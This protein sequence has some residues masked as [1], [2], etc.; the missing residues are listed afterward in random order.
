[1]PIRDP[2]DKEAPAL[3]GIVDPFDRPQAQPE[4]AADAG[5]RPPLRVVVPPPTRAGHAVET[6]TDI[7]S[8]VGKHFSEGAEAFQRSLNPFSESYAKERDEYLKEV[9]EAPWY[10]IRPTVKRN[11]GFGADV[12]GSMNAPMAPI[13]GAAE[14]VLSHGY[15]ALNPIDPQETEELKK[16]GVPV[17]TGDEF[18]SAAMSAIRPGFRPAQVP[19]PVGPP[20]PS[21]LKRAPKPTPG[22]YEVAPGTIVRKELPPKSTVVEPTPPKSGPLGV[23]LSKGQDTLL[24]EGETAALPLIQAEQSAR[25]GILGK[26]AQRRHGRFEAQQEA[27]IAG[28]KDAFLADMNPA[29]TATVEAP[30]DAAGYLAQSL[31]RVHSNRSAEQRA[32]TQRLE[33]AGEVMRS[34]LSPTNTVL[35]RDPAE[36]AN[37]LSGSVAR[38]A[39]VAR[40]VVNAAYRR[41][42]DLPGQFHPATFNRVASDLRARLASPE[43]PAQITL[44]NAQ[45]T[46]QA[47]AAL[48]D[49]QQILGGIA[50]R[51]DP[52]TNRVLPRPPV[53]PRLVENAR[54]RLNTFYGN[55]LSAARS[56]GNWADARAME[57]VMDAFDGMVVEKLRSTFSGGSAGEFMSAITN[58]RQAYRDYRNTYFSR[59]AGDVVGP[60][61]QR[62]LGRHDGQALTPEQLSSVLYSGTNAVPVGRR[63]V[64]V[65]GQ[66]SPEVG[67]IKQGLWSH[68]TEAPPGK[69]PYTFEQVADRIEQFTRGSGRSLTET[70][71]NPDEVRALRLYGDQARTQGKNLS[72][73]ADPIDKMLDR[74]TGNDGLPPAS[75]DDV[76]RDLFGSILKSNEFAPEVIKRFKT[77]FGDD[78]K[79]VGWLKQGTLRQAMDHA[80]SEDPLGVKA[81]A[82]NLY[83]LTRSS[84][85]R[86]LFSA[87]DRKVIAEASDLYRALVIPKDGK[88]W[89]GTGW[90]VSRALESIG[91]KIGAIVAVT[92]GGVAARGAGAPFGIGELAGLGVSWLAQKGVHA[93]NA[94][95]IGKQLPDTKAAWEKYQRAY[96]A[97]TKSQNPMTKK[98]LTA[99]AVGLESALTK[100]GVDASK[101]PQLQL[102][103]TSPAE[104]EE[105]NRAEGGAVEAEN[106]D[107]FNIGMY[108]AT[109]PVPEGPAQPSK[110]FWEA[111]VEGARDS[112]RAGVESFITAVENEYQ[113]PNAV[114]VL[115]SGEWIDAQ[116]QVIPRQRRPNVLPVTKSAERVPDQDHGSGFLSGSKPQ[117]NVEGAMP[118]MLDVWNTTGSPKAAIVAARTGAEGKLASQAAHAADSPHPIQ[119]IPRGRDA[120]A[121]PEL[122]PGFDAY[123]GTTRPGFDRFESSDIEK[124]YYTDRALGTHVAEDPKISSEFTKSKPGA[125]WIEPEGGVYPLRVSDTAKFLEVPQ[126]IDRWG[127]PYHD[128]WAIDRMVYTHVFKKDPKILERY[129]QEARN[130]TDPTLAREA[131]QK[132]ARGD[133]ADWGEGPQTLDKFVA[134]FGGRPYNAADRAAA[135][136]LFK[137]DMQ[138]SG[139]AGLKYV[140]TGTM[141]TQGIDNPTSY[142][143][144]DPHK[145]IQNRLTGQFMA[146]S[147]AEGRVASQIAQS[148]DPKNAQFYSAAQRVL[149][150]ANMESATPEHWLGWLKN[151]PGVKAEELEHLGLEQWA[152]KLTPE[153]PKPVEPLQEGLSDVPGIGHNKP[154][155]PERIPAPII[156]KQEVL[157]QIKGKDLG[158]KEIEYRG[159]DLDEEAVGD[160]AEMLNRRWESGPPEIYSYDYTGGM[161]VALDRRGIVLGV[162][163]DEADAT[164][165]ANALRRD[166]IHA[167]EG[168]DFDVIFDLATD[169]ADNTFRL[170]YQG[171]RHGG[172][173]LPGG[174]NYREVIVTLPLEGVKKTG[175]SEWTVDLDGK[176]F[177]FTD[178]SAA[179]QAAHNHAQIAGRSAE[180]FTAESHWPGV[181]NPLY[182]LR[183]NDRSIPVEWTP[184]QKAQLKAWED[185]EAKLD[186]LKKQQH[187]V[188]K[189][190]RRTAKPL[191]DAHKDRLLADLKAARL[192]Y[193]EFQ[194]KLYGF[195]GHPELLPLQDRM[196]ALRAEEDAIRNSLPPKPEKPFMKTLHIEELQSDWH[197][198]GRKQG[199]KIASPEQVREAQ[200]RMDDAK[201]ALKDFLL[202]SGLNKNEMDN[203]VAHVREGLIPSWILGTKD[204]GLATA[205]YDA[206]Q[207]YHAVNKTTGVPDAPYKKTWAELGLRNALLKA[208]QE[209]KDAISWTP[210]IE[211]AKRYNLAQHVDEIWAQ[212]VSGGPNEGA[213]MLTAKPKGHNQMVDVGEGDIP[214]SK[215]ADYVGKELAEKISKQGDEAETYKGQ[216]LQIGG[217]GM[218]AFYDKMLVNKMNDLGKKYG[219][220]V[221]WRPLEGREVPKLSIKETPL[222]PI[223]DKLPDSWGT[224][225]DPSGGFMAGPRGRLQAGAHEG[226]VWG[227]TPEEA[228]RSA[229]RWYNS[230]AGRE[231]QYGNTP[232]FRVLDSNGNTVSEQ[233][234]MDAAQKYV[235]DKTKPLTQV[236]V[237]RIPPKMRQDIIEKGLP[238]FAEGGSE[239]K[240]ASQAGSLVEE[241]SGVDR[242]KNDDHVKRPVSKKPHSSEPAA[243][244]RAAGGRVVSAN[245]EKNP[246]EAQKSAGNYAKDHISTDGFNITVENAKGHKRSGVGPD[247]KTW[248]CTLPCDYG[249]FKRTEGSDGD[250]VDVYLGPHRKSPQA[251]VIDQ[252]N[253]DTGKF[254]EHKVLLWFGSEKQAIAT[255]KRAFS[256]GKGFARIGAVS[257]LS[258]P[259]LKVWLKHG[260]TKKPFS[261]NLQGKV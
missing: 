176:P 197:Q 159:G 202:A 70:Y 131:A 99:S 94:R 221:E 158:L 185:A 226:V 132:L 53:T 49:L 102:P 201:D 6:V 114:G 141:E 105:K 61:I 165:S 242:Q 239:G 169:A 222:P 60:V 83:N 43:D 225:V 229:L 246:T 175:P 17:K 125:D 24:N 52:T 25:Q 118:A 178:E 235:A 87:A 142:I 234:S 195:E 101:I 56:T 64:E 146:D 110:G 172:Y 18:A 51:R 73:K 156:T 2:F 180:P 23:T 31:S 55:A 32:V 103:G 188:A 85:G 241:E 120:Q 107:P 208:V 4:P 128:E 33:Q 116:G 8:R 88:N 232:R 117:L 127:K 135:I 82:D 210:G 198:Q 196:Q 92:L 187:E 89:S 261:P 251:F 164:R 84:A 15:S 253:P 77:Q 166:I 113:P 133:E 250:H 220:K 192:T 96:R 157:D 184:E 143:V 3:G 62:I 219:A 14:S 68:I 124:G 40:E 199:Y 231:W 203:A 50:Q 123:H 58:A 240:L 97:Y 29:S 115:D 27:E 206:L 212:R 207:N 223:V 237:F 57:E 47:N 183:M 230:H 69:K 215:L 249:Y 256:D 34:R 72:A 167:I 59:G 200:K 44:I 248:E 136:E 162:G 98:A 138:D 227:Q 95:K 16:R 224:I 74:I 160:L 155:P 12:L 218:R 54:K 104:E 63:I 67:A 168:E 7:P 48:N 112:G 245:I 119:I 177:R 86:E 30:R 38:A 149:E 252:I 22:S 144:F 78:S 109:Q 163:R 217:E 153:Q 145:H 170:Y 1:M 139:Y 111:L 80:K 20:V 204:E 41:F 148:L 91:T 9:A 121:V 46:P 19:V 211:Q 209:G 13:T 257:S 152:K 130:V 154:P 243:K 205:Y 36:A 254:D 35:A 151:Q 216:D 255:Y 186:S 193:P 39:E 75:A 182:H 26:P 189:E 42:D 244:Q 228:L 173:Q 129:L 11:L 233:F 260:D 179:L 100:L 236:P 181:K 71:F 108:E 134:N 106:H 93:H 171:T 21:K 90:A 190:I 214:E 79:E 45:T 5:P 65:F 174:E 213:F 66:G 76:A 28:A 161:H 147:G 238:L 126:P 137:R 191:E 37:I 194:E 247:G 150:N 259:L 258:L 81:T 122:Q 140:N 10:D